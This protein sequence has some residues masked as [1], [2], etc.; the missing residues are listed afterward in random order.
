MAL[1][2]YYAANEPNYLT[3]LRDEID[4]IM[5]HYSTFLHDGDYE[6][7]QPYAAEQL[8]VSEEDL[9]ELIRCAW[10][11]NRFTEYGSKEWYELNKIFTSYFKQL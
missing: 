11:L 10:I 1:I 8:Q 6:Y 7:W 3:F 4:V 5:N 2:D 9:P